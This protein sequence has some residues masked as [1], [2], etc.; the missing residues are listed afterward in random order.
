[1]G[2]RQDFLRSLNA[3]VCE[4]K[5]ALLVRPPI[6]CRLVVE[7]TTNGRDV[8]CDYAH[9]EDIICDDCIV[10]GGKFDPRTGRRYRKPKG[11]V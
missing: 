3:T 5:A 8:A 9:G 11:E 7:S 1:M 6:P 2:A 10:N 4:K